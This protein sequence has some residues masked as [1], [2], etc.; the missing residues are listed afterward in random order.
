MGPQGTDERVVGHM[1]VIGRYTPVQ[2]VLG[3]GLVARTLRTSLDAIPLDAVD[4]AIGVREAP[5]GLL[6]SPDPPKRLK[7]ITGP[8]TI[9]IARNSPRPTTSGLTAVRIP[10]D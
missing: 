10:P 6:Q 2:D 4:A 9:S 1:L 8:L 7:A 5:A 3:L